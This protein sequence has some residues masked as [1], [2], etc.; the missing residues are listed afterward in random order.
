MGSSSNSDYNGQAAAQLLREQR[1]SQP[2]SYATPPIFTLPNELLIHITTHLFENSPR[3]DRS[4]R[5]NVKCGPYIN[6]RF[7]R[8]EG[9]QDRLN[10]RLVCK[11][12]AALVEKGWLFGVLSVE[13]TRASV[14]HRLHSE[15]PAKNY[16]TEFV[17]DASNTFEVLPRGQSTLDA[18]LQDGTRVKNDKT[19]N[20]G[21][22]VLIW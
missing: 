8:N 21:K 13:N 14:K 9:H 2:D 5:C 3:N 18:W 19:R 1:A 15:H 6:G 10:F 12:F 20:T 17:F 7:I 22:P 16:V 11:T 4:N